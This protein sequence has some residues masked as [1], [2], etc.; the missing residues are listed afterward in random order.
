MV[1]PTKASFEKVNVMGGELRSLQMAG[2]GTTENGIVM[3][4]RL[5]KKYDH[6]WQPGSKLLVIVDLAFIHRGRSDLDLLPSIF[7]PSV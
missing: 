3:L 4:P 1:V 2:S 7:V 6:V 5:S